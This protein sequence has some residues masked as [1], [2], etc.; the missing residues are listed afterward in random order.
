M[1]NR[2]LVR[3]L[4]FQNHNTQRINRAESK[5]LKDGAHIEKST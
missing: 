3:V 1:F 2:F 5:S 4:N